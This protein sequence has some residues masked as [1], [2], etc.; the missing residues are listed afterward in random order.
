MTPQRTY[1]R[2][3]FGRFARRQ[4]VPR[5]KEGEPMAG[6]PTKVVR[7]KAIPYD[8][9]TGDIPA[10]LAASRFLARS[11]GPR[12]DY[13][14]R[15]STVLESPTPEEAADWWDNPSVCDIAGID[16]GEEIFE[17]RRLA[18]P[19]AQ[20]RIAVLA[21]SKTDQDIIRRDLEG[22]FSPEELERM[23]TYLKGAPGLTVD[24]RRR[25]GELL[26]SCDFRTGNR[27]GNMITV[28][29]DAVGDGV[30]TVHEGVH[31]LRHAEGRSEN[32]DPSG[33]TN[34]VR[35]RTVRDLVRVRDARSEEDMTDMETGCR[36]RLRDICNAERTGGEKVA[37]DTSTISGAIKGDLRVPAGKAAEK[38]HKNCYI[39]TESVD[40]ELR[41]VPVSPHREVIGAYADK[42]AV[43][44]VRRPT[45]KELVSMDVP[46]KD[47][48]ILYEA[49]KAGAEILVTDDK[50]FRS[51]GRGCKDIS[52]VSSEEYLKGNY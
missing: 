18:N 27:P 38:A 5:R 36:I 13:T 30:T 1:K 37:M 17:M 52:V 45:E 32:R 44:R 4:Y 19:E 12:R 34:T 33:R 11:K 29:D 25:D 41:K 7:G 42:H 47:R 14:R 43:K 2:D 48:M 28:S 35:G 51:K 49:R 6:Y 22:A 15:A 39:Y 10:E 16:D 9:S 40:R 50:E 8:P 23:S 24:A 3:R 46:E 26:G 21:N 20:R 31:L